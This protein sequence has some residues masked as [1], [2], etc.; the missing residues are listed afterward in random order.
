VVSSRPHKN[1]LTE[2]M[3]KSR[4]KNLKNNE[5]LLNFID[6]AKILSQEIAIGALAV[7]LRQS[8][9]Q[10]RRMLGRWQGY[11]YLKI[12]KENN[13]SFFKFTARGLNFIE[14]LKLSAG[15]LKW[16]GRWRILIFDV[17]E[18]QRQKRDMLR[19]K[20]TDLGFHQLQKSVWITPYPIPEIF[21]EFLSDIGAH[22]F[23]YSITAEKINREGELKRHFSLS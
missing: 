4:L 7:A 21:T 10:T 11:G 9:F 18:N 23:S 16:D 2:N 14:L 13:K 19:A 22:L 3:L 20:L 12:S 5:L 6:G 17:P 1:A 15:R 8:N